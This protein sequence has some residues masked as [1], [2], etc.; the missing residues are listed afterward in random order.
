MIKTRKPATS[1]RGEAPGH[2]K[3]PMNSNA[4]HIVEPVAGEKTPS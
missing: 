3:M 4:Y 2:K 1:T